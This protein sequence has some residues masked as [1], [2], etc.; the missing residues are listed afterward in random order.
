MTDYF[1]D[2]RAIC[3]SDEIGSGSRISAHAYILRGARIGRDA[4]VSSHVFI[5]DDVVV[6]DRVTILGGVQLWNGVRLEDDVFVGPNATFTNDRF[7]RSKVRPESFATTL[8]ERGA[9]IGAN[10]TI[11]AGVTIGQRAMVGAGAVVT[12]SVPPHAIVVGNPARIRGYAGKDGGHPGPRASRP[13]VV[14]LPG[15]EANDEVRTRASRVAGVNVR[16]LPLHRDLRGSLVACE[17]GEEVPFPVARSFVVF[18]VPS[19]ETR[20]EHAHRECHQFMV[21]VR[22]ACSLGVTDGRAYEDFR[23]SDPHLG[24]HVPPMI[25][26]TQFEHTPD[27]TLLVLAS[28]R[29]DPNDYIRTYEEFLTESGRPKR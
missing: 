7:P 27:A 26:S 19:R 23:L 4:S 11:L 5:E 14:A 15:D 21:C 8:V 25:W 6:G 28:H 24:V 13:G 10:A 1:V 9:S 29:Y 3:E 2:P 22:G 18:D 12:R 20:G 17:I 16:R